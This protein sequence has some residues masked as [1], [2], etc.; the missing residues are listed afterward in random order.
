MFNQSALQSFYKT[1]FQTLKKIEN[2]RSN[3]ELRFY[4]S[5]TAINGILL[6]ALTDVPCLLFGP[7]GV[8]KS[9]LIRSFCEMVGVQSSDDPTARTYFEYLLT[10]FTEPT[11]L[12]GSFR[13]QQ[14]GEGGQALI[15]IETGM[16]HKCRVAFLDEVFNG[17]SAILNSLLAMMNEGKFHDRGEIKHSNLEMIFGATND[18]PN[19]DALNAV[20]DRFVIRTHMDNTDRL[21]DAFKSYLTKAMFTQKDIGDKERYDD[22]LL[23]L[24]KLREDYESREK[25]NKNN[26]MLFDFDTEDA[27]RFLENLTYVTDLAGSLK[28]GTFSNRRVYQLIRALCMQRLMRAARGGSLGSAELAMDE[29]EIIWTHFL[30]VGRPIRENERIQFETLPNMPAMVGTDHEN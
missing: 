30:D 22:L 7:P 10:P 25:S 8:A 2:L 20:F 24:G 19:S 18:L 6:S 9:K 14:D 27:G 23:D 3:L 29:Y 1:H 5:E 13:L 28:L 26:K 15:R 16:L 4:N 21:P 12:F 17:S 11:E